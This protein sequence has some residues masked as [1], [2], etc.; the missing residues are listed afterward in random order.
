LKKKEKILR[1][2]RIGNES[3]LEKMGVIDR[4]KVAK[5][6]TDISLELGV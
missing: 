1:K 5:L 4:E 2:I 6:W 3:R